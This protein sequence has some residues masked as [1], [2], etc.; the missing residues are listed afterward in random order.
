MDFKKCVTVAGILLLSGCSHVVITDPTY[1]REIKPVAPG[2]DL[3]DLPI[4]V[5]ATMD[6]HTSRVGIDLMEVKCN[7]RRRIGIIAANLVERGYMPVKAATPQAPKVTLKVEELNGFL[8]GTTGF[9]NVVTLGILPLYHHEYYT[10]TYTSPSDNIEISKRVK[11]YSTHS[12]ISLFLPNSGGL[13][14]DEIKARA[15]HNLVRAVLDEVKLQ[16]G[17]T[18]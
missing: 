9:L 2:K 15:E 4:S 14:E 6:C 17:T 11:V 12:W 16:A 10:A 13:K 5:E 1:L 3:K 18:P 7:N 8:E